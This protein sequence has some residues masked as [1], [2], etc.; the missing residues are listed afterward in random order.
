MGEPLAHLNASALAGAAIAAAAAFML[1]WILSDSVLCSPKTFTWLGT[2]ENG[3]KKG[4]IDEI[5]RV[6]D[7]VENL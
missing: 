3:A 1:L 7:G 5:E 6:C 4:K 2:I